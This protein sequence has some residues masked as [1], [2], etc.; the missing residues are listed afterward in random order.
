METNKRV[1]ST[2]T[3]I[4]LIFTG[5]TADDVTDTTRNVNER[6]FLAK[7][8]TRC[9]RQCQADRFGEKGTATEVTMDDK[10]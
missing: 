8:E 9:H 4:V 7:R 6:S 2:R 10:S 3:F 5:K 1:G